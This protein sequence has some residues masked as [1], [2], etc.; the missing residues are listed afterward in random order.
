MLCFTRLA[1]LFGLAS[2]VSATGEAAFLAPPAAVVSPTASASATA[3]A[4]AGG[5]ANL[6]LGGPLGPSG[7]ARRAHNALKGY[8][9][10]LEDW[11]TA[12]KNRQI[13]TAAKDA[14]RLART[15]RA[16]TRKARVKAAHVRRNVADAARAHEKVAR[17]E[18]YDG[19]VKRAQQADLKKRV[20]HKKRSEVTDLAPGQKTNPMSDTYACGIG[21]LICPSSYSGVGIPA[22]IQGFCTLHHNLKRAPKMSA[23]RR[24]PPSTSQ[25]ASASTVQTKPLAQRVEPSPSRPTTLLLSLL[26]F[27]SLAGSLLSLRFAHHSVTSFR[28]RLPVSTMNAS[29]IPSPLPY[30]ADKRNVLNQWFVKYGWGWTTAAIALY[31]VATLA[32]PSPS[33]PSSQTTTRA[34]RIVRRYTIATAC[35]YVLTQGTWFLGYG[36]APALAHHILMY[37]GAHCVPASLDSGSLLGQT[38]S[39][40]GE[41]P[42]AAIRVPGA[43]NPKNGEFWKGGH[44][45]S[46]H[47][48]MMVH[49]ILLLVEVVGPS[50]A[51]SLPKPLRTES[52]RETTAP[53]RWATR[54]AMALVGLW[55]W[56]LLMTSLYFHTPA[57]KASGFAFAV[58]AWWVSG[59]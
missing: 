31:L 25:R 57:E 54:A 40:M 33:I 19:I 58:G 17:Q 38:D 42:A 13:T 41:S 16:S 21:A 47:T 9:L 15:V 37:T 28:S 34:I 39:G 22:C 2:I 7:L 12:N 56:M 5:G 26:G 50:L 8:E 49:A 53:V 10:S 45:V 35:W 30:F 51:A 52:S 59:L 4:G 29:A 23:T 14:S 24:S 32:T 1:I 20:D 36:P 18:V 55:W 43:C 27:T 11:H 3:T 46:G 48:F 6:G 44:D